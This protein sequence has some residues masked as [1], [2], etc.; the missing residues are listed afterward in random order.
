MKIE[1]QQS[2]VN[3]NELD[4]KWLEIIE[5]W[6]KSGLTAAEYCRDH[7]GFSYSQFMKQKTRLFPEEVRKAEE[8][9]TTWSTITMEIP[10]A[11][12]DVYI[13]DCRVVVTSG[14]D[15]DLLLEVVE[16]LKHAI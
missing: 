5:E 14:F 8:Q 3:Y 12:I 11:S 9:A 4:Q 7:D 15:Q 10:S 13:N 16:V 6:R 1:E 2:L